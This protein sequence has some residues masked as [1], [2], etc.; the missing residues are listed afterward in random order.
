MQCFIEKVLN[1]L[2]PPIRTCREFYYRCHRRKDGVYRL[3]TGA[4]ENAEYLTYCDMTRDDG[5][6]TLLV[7]S[8]TSGDWILD[9]LRTRLDTKPPGLQM[10][11]SILGHGDDIKS[12]SQDEF[13]YRLEGGGRGEFG[14]IWKAPYNYRLEWLICKTLA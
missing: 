13:E 6:W 1:C 12:I 2:V 3:Q 5:G 11:F 7:S 14:G 8:K 9:N 4:E 10:D